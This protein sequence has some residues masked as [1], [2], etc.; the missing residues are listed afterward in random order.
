M[1]GRVHDVP[2]KTVAGTKHAK[3]MGKMQGK[4]CVDMPNFNMDDVEQRQVLLAGLMTVTFKALNSDV[5][6]TSPGIVSERRQA[7]AKAKFSEAKA[8][9]SEPVPKATTAEQPNVKAKPNP[10][11]VLEYATE[12]SSVMI[13][14][15]S[16]SSECVAQP[17]ASW[18]YGPGCILLWISHNKSCA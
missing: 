5:F 1:S 17:A 16:S 18:A 8:K 10:F 13:E 11:H 2:K 14:E 6:L 7:E 3:S 15:L 9:G 4:H 12:N